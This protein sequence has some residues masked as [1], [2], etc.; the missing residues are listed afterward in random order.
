MKILPP[1]DFSECAEQA[2]AQAFRLARS[3]GAELILFH[4]RVEALLAWA[5]GDREQ[6]ASA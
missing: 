6:W 3:L 5:E 2:Q 4:V 1:T